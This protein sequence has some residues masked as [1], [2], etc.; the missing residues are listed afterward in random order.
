M[1]AAPAAGLELVPRHQEQLTP[2]QR[3]MPIRVPRVTVVLSCICSM[4]ASTAFRR[5]TRS[6]V[7][8]ISIE[9]VRSRL[10][11]TSTMPPVETAVALWV[12]VVLLIPITF[13]KLVGFTTVPDTCIVSFDAPVT[14]AD[15]VNENVAPFAPFVYP[16]LLKKAMAACRPS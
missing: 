11:I 1:S 6:L 16:L 5:F 10:S 9:P 14:D 13:Q 12:I 7:P 3:A 15:G 4:N 2:A 8:D